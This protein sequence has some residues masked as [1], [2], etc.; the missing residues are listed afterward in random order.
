MTKTAILK[1]YFIENANLFVP[2]PGFQIELDGR[3]IARIE[4]FGKEITYIYLSKAFT[5]DTAVRNW[6]NAKDEEFKVFE[7]AEVELV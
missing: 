7:L 1:K 3:R 2:K 6:L 4:G 5:D